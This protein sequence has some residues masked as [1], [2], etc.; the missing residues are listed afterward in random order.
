[1]VRQSMKAL[2]Q[3]LPAIMQSLQQRASVD[4]LANA[5]RP[6]RSADARLG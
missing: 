2:N 6:I 3:A 1:M 4:A 5:A